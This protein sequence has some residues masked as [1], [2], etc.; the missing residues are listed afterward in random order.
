L[1]N[2]RLLYQFVIVVPPFLFLRMSISILIVTLFYHT[3]PYLSTL[4]EKKYQKFF[5]TFANPFIAPHVTAGGRLLIAIAVKL[6]QQQNCTIAWIATDSITIT[7]AGEDAIH[8]IQNALNNLNPYPLDV[9]PQLLKREEDKCGWGYAISPNR[10]CI[11]DTVHCERSEAACCERSVATC[12]EWNAANCKLKHWTEH[13]L[14][15]LITPNG[16]SLHE[17]AHTLW[18]AALTNETPPEWKQTL[19]RRKVP[20][21][22]PTEWKLIREFYPDVAPFNFLQR[23]KPAWVLGN[24]R[25]AGEF[26]ALYAPYRNTNKASLKLTWIAKQ[27]CC[28]G[29]EATC[30]ERSVAACCERSEAN[31]TT[32]NVKIKPANPDEPAAAS[33][34][35]I[36]V[37]SGVRQPVET[38]YA[39]YQN[40]IN[41]TDPRMITPQGETPYGNTSGQ[42]YSQPLL[43]KG[44]YPIGREHD[45]LDNE[46]DDLREPVTLLT[47]N[48]INTTACCEL[49]EAI[50]CEQRAAACCERNVATC[51]EWN[52]ATL[53][54]IRKLA[55]YP[56]YLV[57]MALGISTRTWR[58]YKKGTRQP[59]NLTSRKILALSVSLPNSPPQTHTERKHLL[60]NIIKD[61]N[62]PVASDT[63]Q[64]VA[65]NARQPLASEAKQSIASE[66]RQIIKTIGLRSY[67]KM[68]G[69]DPAHLSTALNG[70]RPIPDSW[71]PK[72]A[73]TNQRLLRT[74]CGRL[75]RAQRGKIT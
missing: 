25:L 24:R 63:R 39:L 56:N 22:T 14:G 57:A 54:A 10:Y 75:L 18:I 58:H 23:T 8:H 16:E 65:S 34:D 5:L 26:R 52:A 50:H 61:M 21:R 40:F 74:E 31:R 37:A 60:L 15:A 7:G 6:L 73:A 11:I 28:E 38:L 71:L 55:Q 53:N 42:L 20:I 43:I 9:I 30:R 12:C 3:L 49:S 64:P 32:K 13:G 19:A 36:L 1:L 41:H 67:A 35:T 27:A 17:F 29:N 45:R 44:V 72:L 33:Y 47:D 70:K 59:N 62:E 68:A 51:C 69:L 46:T 66:T 4:F 48:T 2:F